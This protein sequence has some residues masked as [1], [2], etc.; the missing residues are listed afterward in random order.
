MSALTNQQ[1]YSAV[2]KAADHIERHPELFD[3][4]ER[5]GPH[6]C[7]TPACALGRIGFFAGSLYEFWDG[8]LSIYGVA[9]R[10]FGMRDNGDNDGATT[11]YTR[12][13]QLVGHDWKVDASICAKGLRLL[14]QDYA[15]K[16]EQGSFVDWFQRHAELEVA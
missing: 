13:N 3:F 10:T 9:Y 2:M 5:S 15:P 11:F 12:M 16:V 14:A 6:D 8:S 7:G 1:V 4:D